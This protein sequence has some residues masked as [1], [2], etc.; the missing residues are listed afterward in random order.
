MIVGIDKKA[1][2]V[3]LKQDN[4]GCDSLVYM[5]TTLIPPDTIFVSKE[6]CNPRDTGVVI[7]QIDGDDGCMDIQK[8]TTTYIEAWSYELEIHDISCNDA[9][10]GFISIV[11]P[12]D[13]TIQ[14]E[15]Q[16]NLSIRANLSAGDYPVTISGEN[17]IIEDVFTI[18]NP[19]PLENTFQANEG[20]CQENGGIIQSLPS[21][22]TP[23]YTF[24]WSN[25]RTTSYIDSLPSGTYLLTITDDHDCIFID[26]LTLNNKVLLLSLN[27]QSISCNGFEDGALELVFDAGVPPYQIEWSTGDTT[28]RIEPL[29]V[30]NYSVVVKDA[31]G[32]YA[33]V[34]SL[35]QEPDNLSITFNKNFSTN[36]G[37]GEI[38]AFVTGGTTPYDYLWSTGSTAFNIMDVPKGVY[39]VTV[40]DKNGC[41]LEDETSLTT[42]TINAVDNNLAI[43]LYPNPTNDQFFIDFGEKIKS[44]IFIF[45]SNGN[46]VY[47]TR[48]SDSIVEIKGKKVLFNSGIYFVVIRTKYGDIT[49]KIIFIND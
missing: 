35:M 1:C 2:F 36:S 12:D 8:T 21:G 22:G 24:N 15:D 46:L 31:N 18:K 7:T 11:V 5:I 9:N 28:A 13:V 37:K 47:S 19:S 29:S 42:S 38:Q 34:S 45:S 14:W 17:C 23:P 44:S 41:I 32:C 43:S 10:D 48:K 6:S 40:T 39:T 30:G 20:N 26:S 3:V 16:S 33:S 27:K 4:Y 25:N 49:Q